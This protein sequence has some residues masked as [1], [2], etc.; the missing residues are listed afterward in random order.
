M[1]AIKVSSVAELEAL[2]GTEL[3]PTE[4]KTV[5]QTRIDTFAEVTEDRQW[6]HVDTE[7]A[8]AGPFRGT[9]GHGLL[10]LSLGPAMA[11]E[12]IVFE[13]FPHTLNY[14]FGKVRFPAPTPV[15]SWVRMRLVISSVEPVAGGVQLTMTEIFEREGGEKPICVAEA[16]ARIVEG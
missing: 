16:L 14:G 9:I 10:T 5:H 7:R 15:D 8:A 4:W 12:L 1:S 13:G 6:I 11:E 3:G 2:V